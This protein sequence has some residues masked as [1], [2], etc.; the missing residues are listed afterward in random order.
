M[1]CYKRHLKHKN[2]LRLGVKGWERI[3]QA[4]TNNDT[5]KPG[6]DA[7]DLKRKALLVEELFTK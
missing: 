3:Y 2:S 4:H 1:K 5:K 6:D 7:S